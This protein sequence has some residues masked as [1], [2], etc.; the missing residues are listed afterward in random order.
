ME[1][2]QIKVQIGDRQYEAHMEERLIAQWPD[3]RT[4][5]FVVIDGTPTPHFPIEIND[6]KK[7]YGKIL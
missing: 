6:F 5:T 3:Q 4:R 1:Q 2:E 7:N